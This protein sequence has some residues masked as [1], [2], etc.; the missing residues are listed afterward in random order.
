MRNK[1]FENAFTLRYQVNDSGLGETS[2]IV[3]HCFDLSVANGL[4]RLLKMVQMCSYKT[5]MHS[6]CASILVG[7]QSDKEQHVKVTAIQQAMQQH[8]KWFR[9]YIQV[10]C[11]TRHNIEALRKRLDSRIEKEFYCRFPKGESCNSTWA[12][13]HCA[14]N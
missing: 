3:L 2:H 8:P 1:I 13:A 7:C 11:V 12:D 6:K 5:V 4:D 14:V 10:S 9:E